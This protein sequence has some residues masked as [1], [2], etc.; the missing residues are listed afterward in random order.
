MSL[1][2]DIITTAE[3][4]TSRSLLTGCR[5]PISEDEFRIASCNFYNKEL[6][7]YS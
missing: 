4:T 2:Q 1:T 7:T 6:A 5:I 3:E